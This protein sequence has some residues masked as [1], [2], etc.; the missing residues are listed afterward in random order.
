MTQN[1]IRKG[2]LMEFD[3]RASRFITSIAADEWL[4]RYDILVDVAHLKML[5][6]QAIISQTTCKTLI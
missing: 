4:F 5:Y 6:K 1:I 3:E 2:R